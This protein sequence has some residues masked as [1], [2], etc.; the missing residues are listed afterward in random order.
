MEIYKLSD[1]T[2]GDLTEHKKYD[3][4]GVESPDGAEVSGYKITGLKQGV[5]NPDR[6]NVYVNSKF[7]FSLDVAQ[8]VDFK[9]KVGLVVSEE[10]LAEF[11]KASEFGKLYQRALEW[12]LVRPRS[13]KECRDYL[14]RKLAKLSSDT[15]P[16]ARL[17]GAQPLPVAPAGA[18]KSSED[19]RELSLTIIERLKSRGYLDDFKFAEYYVEN[20]FVKKGVSLKRLRME[21]MK[22]GVSKEIVEEVLAG[23]GRNDEEEI[24]K[25]IVKKRSRYTDEK[26]TAYLVRQGFSYDLVRE[27][28]E[29]TRED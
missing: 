10:Q 7:A 16:R 26:L 29:K 6:V 3:N 18:T 11:K 24:R 12:A 14:W 28:I 15:R 19:I 2:L 25:M 9:I 5:R 1:T 27:L 20:R 13:E 21:L 4:M 23:S 8:V 17:Y 22:K